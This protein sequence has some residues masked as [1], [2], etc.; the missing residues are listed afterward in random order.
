MTEQIMTKCSGCGAQLEGA[1]RKRQVTCPYCGTVNVFEKRPASEHEII[2]PACGTANKREFEHCVECGQN[3][4]QNCPKCGTRNEA[5]ASFCAM[6]GLDLEKAFRIQRKYF[7]YL[8]E[9]R[10]IIKEYQRIYRTHLLIGYA[11]IIICM[12]LV[13]TTDFTSAGFT[14]TSIAILAGLFVSYG[15]MFYG[16]SK[17]QKYAKDEVQKAQYKLTGFDEFYKLYAKRN[18]ITHYW[19]AQM[20]AGNKLDRFTTIA[21]LNVK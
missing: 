15:I 11:G 9:A 13:L 19:P 10:Q 2:C 21:K 8:A 14:P 5:D 6:C 20:V 4:Y 7:E 12:I 3:L 16:N 17:G 18:R 1:G